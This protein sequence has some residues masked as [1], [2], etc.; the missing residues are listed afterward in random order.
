M[1]RT[2]WAAVTLAA[3]SLAAC[4]N[5]ASHVGES[6]SGARPERLARSPVQNNAFV[7]D[8]G[9][10]AEYS[11]ANNWLVRFSE[12][13]RVSVQGP[14]MIARGT[15]V[16]S[17]DRAQANYTERDGGVPSETSKITGYFALSPDGKELILQTG[18]KDDA[19]VRLNR[20]DI[21]QTSR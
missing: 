10:I 2:V 9:P 18:I 19:P 21:R 13:G 11:A 3:I 16:A 15:Y 1:M 7:G 12:D 4:G 14:G 8:W 5:I 20:I 17:G 6:T